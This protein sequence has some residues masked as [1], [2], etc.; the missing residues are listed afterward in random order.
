MSRPPSSRPDPLAAIEPSSDL[1]LVVLRPSAAPIEGAALER[2]L[3]GYATS[4]AGAEAAVDAQSAE[5][6]TLLGVARW[7]RHVVRLVGHPVP[8]PDDALVLTLDAAWMEEA[9]RRAA[10]AHRAHLVLYYAGEDDS[11]FEQYLAL[12]AVAGALATLGAL[13]VVNEPAHNALSGR[14]LLPEPGAGD[15]V[16]ALASMPLLALWVG[17]GRHPDP[18][19]LWLRTHGAFLL[20]LPDL[21]RHV[22]GAKARAA[23]AAVDETVDLFEGIFEYLIES[24]APVEEGHTFALGEAETLALRAPREDETALRS[25]GEIYALEPA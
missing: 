20:G 10:R 19:G 15:M 11:P 25:E 17:L 12:G 18:T 7:D 2:A 13:A 6:G 23:Q 9:D 21:A 1:R 5:R 8:L 4:L 24:G 14:A 16:D 3:R 22:P